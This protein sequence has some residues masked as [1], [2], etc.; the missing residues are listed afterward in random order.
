[1]LQTNG[2]F[3]KLT[4]TNM[5]EKF[6]STIDRLRDFERVIKD[7]SQFYFLGSE[8]YYFPGLQIFDASI[9]IISFFCNNFHIKQ[10]IKRDQFFKIV[11]YFHQFRELEPC[12]M[13]ISHCFYFDCQRLYFDLR[14]CKISLLLA[15]PNYVIKF[16]FT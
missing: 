4:H 5:Y 2:F 11:I 14:I 6:V 8:R 12:S 15:Y 1:M 7:K 13:I 16:Q 3:L 10:R 9:L